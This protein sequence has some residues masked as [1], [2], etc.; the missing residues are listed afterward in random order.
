MSI[1][2]KLATAIV[3]VFAAAVVAVSLATSS[4]SS[5]STA[6]D[7]PMAPSFTLAPLGDSVQRIT[8]AQ[9]HGEPVIVNFWASWCDP[10][11]KETPLLARWYKQQH[12]RVNL[13]GLD[14]ND[15]AA[16]ALRFARAKG[17]TYPVGVDTALAAADGFGVT[18]LPQTFFLDSRHRIVDRVYGAVTQADLA[19]GVRLM[20]RGFSGHIG[21][22]SPD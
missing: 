20:E 12:G 8:L 19:N 10:C 9:Y 14:E 4:G 11:Q 17:V 3:A 2:V 21:L 18:A 16:A 15:S 1:R 7:G 5:A 6:H 22:R 13:V